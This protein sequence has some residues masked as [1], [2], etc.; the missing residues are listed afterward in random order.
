M[1]DGFGLQDLAVGWSA[2]HHSACTVVARTGLEV[3][4][5]AAVCILELPAELILQIFECTATPVVFLCSLLP[6]G[7]GHDPRG[8]SHGRTLTNVSQMGDVNAL[9]F[10]GG[11]GACD[12][13]APPTCA[14]GDGGEGC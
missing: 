1:V 3:S 5:W 4:C 13:S 7:G 2:S 9:T 11:Q 8:G 12:A 6:W 14:I 10:N